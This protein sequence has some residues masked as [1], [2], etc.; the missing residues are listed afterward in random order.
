M[1]ADIINLRRV[2]KAKARTEAQ[3]TAAENRVKS[4]RTKA[5]RAE[6]SAVI[7]LDHSRLDGAKRSNPGEDGDLDPGTVP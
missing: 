7:K 3:K 6:V 2:R 5:E 4:G 1:P